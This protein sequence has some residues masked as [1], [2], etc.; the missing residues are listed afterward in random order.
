MP[1]RSAPLA[2]PPGRS[3]WS[4]W[5]ARRRCRRARLRA[6]RPAGERHRGVP[7]RQR[8]VHPRPEPAGRASSRSSRS[9]P[10]SCGR[11]RTASTR[12]PSPRS[13]SG[14]QAATDVAEEADALAAP[15]TP[16]IPSE[17]GE[18][19]QAF[20]PLD[21]RPEQRPAPGGRGHPRG[22]RARRDGLLRHG[23]GRDLRRLLQRLRGH[24]QPADPRR[25]RHRPAD[26]AGRLPQ[27]DPAAAGHR[28][29]RPGPDRR[30]RRGLPAGRQ[31]RHH[32]QRAEPGHRGDPGRRR[33]HRL[34]P[35]PGRPVPRGTAARGVEVHR[36]VDRAP[37]VLGA[38]RRLRHH[39]RPRRPLPAALRPRL[40]PRARAD[41][42]G[43]RH[44]RGP[45]RAQLPSGRARA[46]GS[47][48]V[49]AVPPRVRHRAEA[50][51]WMAARGRGWSGAVPGACS[52]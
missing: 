21:A 2:P 43:E 42:G 16:L 34:R 46:A 22:H 27:P 50:R 4:G 51:P 48:R 18:A 26:P 52:S 37:P 13:A 11:T 25:V 12:P 41:L 7:P 36:D 44:P 5:A 49:L 28:H 20:L 31:R 14:S 32:R 39:R 35:A 8:R 45:G 10:S 17:D 6:D 30:Q 40:Q 33:G 47:R 38:D 29:G 23:P 1:R 3:C 15:A 19:V 9:P 24:R